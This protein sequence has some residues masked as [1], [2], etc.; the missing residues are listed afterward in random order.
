ML[1]LQ[2]CTD[3]KLHSMIVE[4]LLPLKENLY[5]DLFMI[6]AYGP[7]NTRIPAI[8]LL[9]HYWPQLQA[10]AGHSTLSENKQYAVTSWQVPVCQ[11]TRCINKAVRPSATKVN[12][13]RGA[14]SQ[15]S[16]VYVVGWV[17]LI[18][19]YAYTFTGLC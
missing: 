5:K 2:H 15:I 18:D 6:V 13:T 7:P 8:K 3:P 16:Y 14:V 12:S 19:C 9:F 4:T 1:V 17:A 10:I 11:R